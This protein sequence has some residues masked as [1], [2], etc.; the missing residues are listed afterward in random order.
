MNKSVQ[1][2]Y[3][4]NTYSSSQRGNRYKNKFDT[5]DD[6]EFEKNAKMYCK[7]KRWYEKNGAKSSKPSKYDNGKTKP[8]KTIR[9][10]RQVEENAVLKE[11][12]TKEVFKFCGKMK[13]P[14]ESLHPDS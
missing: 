12:T 9:I 1:E 3:L 8:P 7:L 10:V 2:I 11:F 4:D 13:M 5:I 14:I 6:I